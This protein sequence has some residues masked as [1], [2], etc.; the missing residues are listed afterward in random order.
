MKNKVNNR[1]LILGITVLLIS[2]SCKPS[3]QKS[4]SIKG[5]IKGLDSGT[6]LLRKFNETDR[7]TKTLDS[8]VVHQ[9]HFELTGKLESP[10]MLTLTAR[11]G[12]WGTSIF[13]ENSE[14]VLDADTSGAEHYDYTPYGGDKGASLKKVKISG[15]GNQDIYDR[16]ENDPD[17]LHFKK[18]FAEM[19]KQYEAEKN[20]ELKEKMRSKFDSVGKLSSAWQ[21]KWINAFLQKDSG[22][23]AGAYIFNNYYRSNTSMPLTDMDALL[24]KFTGDAKKSIYYTNLIKEANLRR[25]LL[26]GKTAP[27]FTLLKRDSTSFTLSS[28]RGKYIMLDFWA[29]WCKPCREAIPHWKEVYAKYKDKGFEIISVSD[30]SRKADWIKAMDQEK[31]PWTQVVDEFPVKNMPARVGT[32]YQTHFIPF[33][34]L[35]D[36]EGKILVYSGNEKDID[37]KLKD[38]L[39]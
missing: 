13:V 12:N 17:Q 30:D 37:A 14:I 36:K 34:V 16:F 8:V 32:L 39:M 2:A 28:T 3:G 21:I 10:E 7:T 25:A 38:L 29:S 19:N 26:P 5:T 4:F 9:G 22:S 1:Y 18:V 31:M 11:P 35:L 33:Y 24:R 15:S 23:S 6:V 27:D 20:P